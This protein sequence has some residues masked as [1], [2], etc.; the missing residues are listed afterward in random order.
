[1]IKGGD[2]MGHEARNEEY[3]AL[4]IAEA[5]WWNERSVLPKRTPPPAPPPTLK[6][7]P[8]PP[9]SECAL[10]ISES[11]LPA[12]YVMSSK[13]WPPPSPLHSLRQLP[14]NPT[15]PNLHTFHM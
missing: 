7:S 13:Y 10:P 9:P 8:P 1:M 6:P 2:Y 4:Q 5:N 3:R 11:S 15:L 14:G 12:P